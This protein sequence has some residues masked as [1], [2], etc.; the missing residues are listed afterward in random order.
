MATSNCTMTQF[1][2]YSSG[3]T[4]P[5]D[6]SSNG[7]SARFGPSDGNSKMRVVIPVSIP[8]I[9]SGSKHNTLTVSLKVCLIQEY[10][11]TDNAATMILNVSNSNRSTSTYAI[12][13][14][15]YDTQQK[16]QYFG[17]ASVY[18]TV[19]WTLDIS[20]DTN[21]AAHTLYLW[22]WTTPHNNSTTAYEVM[23]IS[24]SGHSASI[25][26]TLPTYKVTY[27][28]NGGSGTMS[29]YTIDYNGS[30][31][32]QSNQFTPPRGSNVTCTITLNPNYTGGLSSSVSLNNIIPKK[33]NTWRQGST[34]G[35]ERAP[36]TTI[37]NI[38]SNIT[39]YAIWVDDTIQK[40][41]V[42]LGALTRS[43]ESV[44]GYQVSFDTQGGSSVASITSTRKVTYTH[45]GWMTS[46][47]GTSISYDKTTAYSFTV[48]TE[49]FAK[50]TTEYTNNSIILPNAPTKLGY[51]FLGWGTS[52][53][54][55]SYKQP[56]ESVTPSAKTTYYA[57]WEADGSIRIYTDNTKKYQIAMVWMYKPNSSSDN[58]P[59]KLVIPYMKTDINWKITAG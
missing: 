15:V 50:W 3:W 8:A 6:I 33:F 37:S 27:N 12:Q 57:V 30:H 4:G 44:T 10:L 16:Y 59:W 36:G 45:D 48:N 47:N 1:Y 14:T 54:A 9:T 20:N 19:T 56:G 7:N 26:Y 41:T 18:K 51:N 46:A 5:K 29:S 35:T 49:L 2:W 52:A 43:E 25:D 17:G 31:T 23:S 11:T 40:G 39:L 22:L 58:K 55:T 21:T 13:G 53:N 34:S 28:A 32:V 24:T 38:T 42:V